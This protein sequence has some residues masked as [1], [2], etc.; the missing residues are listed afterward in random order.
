MR[1]T[2]PVL[3]PH[4]LRPRP[5]ARKVLIALLTIGMLRTIRIVLVETLL[6]GK[7]DVAVLAD[8]MVLRGLRVLLI[9]S[10]VRKRPLAAI[11][12]GH[13]L[14]SGGCGETSGGESSARSFRLDPTDV[15]SSLYIHNGRLQEVPSYSYCIPPLFEPS[16]S[17]ASILCASSSPSHVPES[18]SVSA[19]NNVERLIQRRSLLGGYRWRCAMQ[20]AYPI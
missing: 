18:G 14:C 16:I 15:N 13:R 9:S 10:V 20:C 7:V 17:A 1:L 8:P 12:I 19:R 5:F 4:M 2:I 11:A 3:G 6:A